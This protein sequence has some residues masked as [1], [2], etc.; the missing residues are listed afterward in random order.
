M[1]IALWSPKDPQDIRDYWIDFSSLLAGDEKI[2]TATSSVPS[3]Q[4][5]PVS[6]FVALTK[7]DGDFTD[8]MVR[9]RLAGGSVSNY[10][11]QYHITTDTGQEFDLSKTL[12][13][14]ERTA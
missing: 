1:A 7:T 9:V 14:K 4:P 13:V 11:I 6:P 10:V 12:E 8:K 5:V 3:G 2:I